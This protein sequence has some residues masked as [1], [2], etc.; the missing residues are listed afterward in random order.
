MKQALIRLGSQNPKL[1]PHVQTILA[2]LAGPSGSGR[3]REAARLTMDFSDEVY[4][5]W[6]VHE[7]RVTAEAEGLALKAA[8][9]LEKYGFRVT[10]EGAHID[11][12][13]LLSFQLNFTSDIGDESREEIEGMVQSVLG[14]GW[15]VWASGKGWTIQFDME[16]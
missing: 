2:A 5:L 13:G 10:R 16:K 12:N 8:K 9:A 3:R 14:Y 6:S 1:R 7:K 4:A 15:T 11:H